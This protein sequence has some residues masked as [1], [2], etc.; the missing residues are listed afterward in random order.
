VGRASDNE[1]LVRCAA[2]ARLAARGLEDWE[3]RQRW[4]LGTIYEQARGGLSETIP[5]R[6]A[7]RVLGV[8]VSTLDRW[9]ARGAVD[10]GGPPG[11]SR[12]EVGTDI[13]IE[14]ACELRLGRSP[15]RGG[16]AFRGALERVWRR[17]LHAADERDDP[18]W[19]APLAGELRA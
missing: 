9:I 7:A 1:R 19:A 12:Q 18:E 15:R 16:D 6:V 13:V 4:L 2:A 8:N 11:T 14:L 10:C 17:R 3:T 5:K